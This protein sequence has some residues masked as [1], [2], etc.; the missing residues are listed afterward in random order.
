MK[1]NYLVNKILDK[2][3][4]NETNWKEK[5]GG[6]KSFK[7]QQGDYDEVQKMLDKNIYEGYGITEREFFY[8]EDFF[9]GKECVLKEAKWLAKNNLIEIIWYSVGNDIEKI[10]YSLQHISNFYEIAQRESKFSSSCKKSQ[11]LR[12]Y[13]EKIHSDWIK[14]YYDVRIAEA[15]KGQKSETDEM[16]GLLFRCLSS[17]EKLDF[18]IYIRTFSSKYLGNSKIFEEKLKTKIL[19]IAKKYHPQVDEEMDDYQIYEQLFLDTYSQELSLKG[20]LIIS[21]NGKEI[22]LSVFINGTVLNSETLKNAQIAKNQQIKKIISVENKANFVSMPYEEGILILFSHGFFSPLEREFLKKLESILEHTDFEEK[23]GKSDCE[24]S[25][26]TDCILEQSEKKNRES[27][28]VKTDKVEYFHT[29]DL[30]YGGIRIFQYIRTQIFPKLKPYQMSV[31]QF[32]KYE[33]Q[34]MEIEDSKLQKLQ[35]MKEPLLQ[36]LIEYI[37][38]TKKVIEQENFL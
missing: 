24:C 18:P 15:E 36:E 11:K 14:T 38:K 23:V 4:K 34:A 20:N 32:K 2:Y 9:T 12:E 1:N 27:V 8:A 10:K 3:E 5:K 13:Q 25:L 29:G 16:D 22:D 21:L 30:D 7:I 35:I 17:I 37:C 6:N 26:Y 28:I 33:E 19:T 31:E